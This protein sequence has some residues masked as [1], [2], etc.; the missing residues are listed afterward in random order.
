M[1]HIIVLYMWY[2]IVQCVLYSIVWYSCGIVLYSIVCI[3]QCGMC[4][5][6]MYSIVW[7]SC[8]IVLYSI[9]C[10]VYVVCV[11]YIVLYSVSVHECE[12]CV[13]MN[14]CVSGEIRGER[15]GQRSRGD[16]REAER[17]EFSNR[18]RSDLDLVA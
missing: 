4:G 16:P 17:S 12:E 3:V 7:Y 9:V 10:V 1:P 11:V 13:D 18:R 14:R 15:R 2:S 6:V 8:G 5:I